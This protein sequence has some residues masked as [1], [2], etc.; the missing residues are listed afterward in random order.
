MR[1][2]LHS[3]VL[4]EWGNWLGDVVVHLEIVVVLGDEFAFNEV[5]NSTVDHCD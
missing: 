1:K 4:I 2:I 3:T 5:V